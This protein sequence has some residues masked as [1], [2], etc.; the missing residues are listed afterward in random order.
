MIKTK[1]ILILL[2]FAGIGFSVSA[3]ET[4]ENEDIGGVYG[5]HCGIA[6]QQPQFRVKIEEW[7]S[8]EKVAEINEWLNSENKV[9]N[10]Y[11]AEAFIRLHNSKKVTL[12]SRQLA[13][14][15]EL[16]SSSE[17][18][19]SCSGCIHSLKTMK[20]ALQEFNL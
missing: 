1:M 2:F 14:I 13:K 12:N 19:F 9:K 7:I 15:R 5:T 20:E 16:K 10:V 4:E 11:A 17:E 18:I 3:Q 6:G 8:Q